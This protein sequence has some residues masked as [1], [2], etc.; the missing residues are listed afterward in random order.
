MRNNN[1]VI[2]INMRILFFEERI[3]IQWMFGVDERGYL[4]Q[5]SLEFS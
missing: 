1:D 5:A 2:D 4:W 3:E